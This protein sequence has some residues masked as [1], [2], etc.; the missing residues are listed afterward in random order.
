M[1]G[2][3]K[4]SFPRFHSAAA[5]RAGL[6]TSRWSRPT[7]SSL[8]SDITGAVG[9]RSA[10]PSLAVARPDRSP[11][12]AGDPAASHRRRRDSARS[13]NRLRPPVA[14]Q[15]VLHENRVAARP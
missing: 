13:R 2:R 3:T 6:R 9:R 4:R 8:I 10:V 11:R 15:A 1:R 7:D 12:R 14:D 5:I